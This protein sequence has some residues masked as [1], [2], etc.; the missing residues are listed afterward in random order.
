MKIALTIAGFD[1]SSGAGITADLLTFQAHGLFGISAITA[2]TV[3][4]TRGV[5]ASE[6]LAPE[7]LR[8][9][10][11]CLSA[12]LP[13]AGIKIGMLATPAN[14]LVVAEFLSSIRLR[15]SRI[16]VVLDPVLRSSS[17]H[18]LLDSEGAEFLRRLLLPLVDWVT[19]NA[20]EL[21]ALLEEGPISREGLPDGARKLQSL[22]RELNVLV[23]GGDLDT[24]D[25]L[26]VTAS[27]EALWLAGVRIETP[28][29]HGTGCALSSALLSRLVLG[30]RNEVA[31][32]SAKAYVAG[33]LVHAPGL[34][35]GHG[36]LDHLWPLRAR[37]A[38]LED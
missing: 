1:P 8:K 31:A 14:V 27:G 24:P 10:L 30:L 29:T 2:I 15:G 17:G 21:A 22:G 25:D 34:G 33:A 35:S 7:T 9:T 13:A 5:L 12:D 38:K 19:P 37:G 18:P 16:P 28:S 26:L 3:Q 32:R 20:V 36:P 4:S 11:E 6:P 23:T